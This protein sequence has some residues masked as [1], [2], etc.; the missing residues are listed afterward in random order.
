LDWWHGLGIEGMQAN[1]VAKVTHW[2]IRTKIQGLPKQALNS[3]Q[4]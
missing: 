4:L 3:S 2:P 1:W